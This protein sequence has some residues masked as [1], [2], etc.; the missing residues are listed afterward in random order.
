MILLTLFLMPRSTTLR[1]PGDKFI[2]RDDAVSH[3]EVGVTPP[4]D[5]IP[6]RSELEPELETEDGKMMVEGEASSIEEGGVDPP[7]EKPVEM[8]N[9]IND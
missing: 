6:S 8:S 4:E 9:V 3:E 7:Q 2:L 1:E 5:A